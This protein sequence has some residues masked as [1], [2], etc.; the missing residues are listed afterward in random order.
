MP[1]FE[2]DHPIWDHVTTTITELP[3]L[4]SWCDEGAYQFHA[5]IFFRISEPLL[6]PPH[7]ISNAGIIFS[8][9][10]DADQVVPVL[11]N[12]AWM[13]FQG[14]PV[15]WEQSFTAVFESRVAFSA[16]PSTT[17]SGPG[18]QVEYEPGSHLAATPDGRVAV[19]WDDNTGGGT[20]NSYYRL[21]N[22]N[23]TPNTSAIMIRT[24]VRSSRVA[25]MSNM[26]IVTG[27][28]LGAAGNGGFVAIRNVDTG[29]IIDSV[30]FLDS[31]PSADILESVNVAE[32]P[33]GNILAAYNMRGF[34]QGQFRIFDGSNLS[35]EPINVKTF[36]FGS[37]TDTLDL[38]LQAGN[39]GNFIIAYKNESVGS[40][41]Y[42]VFDQGGTLIKHGI[43]STVGFDN[44]GMG[45]TTLPNGNFVVS[46]VQPQASTDGGY[47]WVHL[48][49]GTTGEIIQ[50]REIS[51]PRAIGTPRYD[52]G[53]ITYLRNNN[54][55]G[56]YE[57]DNGGFTATSW[58]TI[59]FELDSDL[60]IVQGISLAF[61][62]RSSHPGGWDLIADT[63][64]NGKPV[65]TTVP[66]YFIAP[67]ADVY[68]QSLDGN[69][70]RWN[71][72]YPLAGIKPGIKALD[73]PDGWAGDVGPNFTKVRVNF[74]KVDPEGA[75]IPGFGN[76]TRVQLQSI[77]NPGCTFNRKQVDGYLSGEEI[78]LPTF[79]EPA[80]CHV[81]QMLNWHQDYDTPVYWDSIEYFTPPNT[82]QNMVNESFWDLAGGLGTWNGSGIDSEDL[83]THYISTTPDSRWH[84]GFRP[85]KIKIT[86]TGG[87]ID[88]LLSDINAEV[89]NN[90]P[91]YVSDTEI[92]LDWVGADIYY[93]TL[94]S[95]VAPFTVTKIEFLTENN[96]RLH[97]D[98][99]ILDETWV[100]G[101]D[102]GVTEYGS[103]SHSNLEW[104]SENVFPAHL[105]NVYAREGYAGV[106]WNEGYRPSKARFYFTGTIHEIWIRDKNFGIMHYSGAT[107]PSSGT[108]VDVA[109]LGFDLQQCHFSSTAGP[110]TVWRIEFLV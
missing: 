104:S 1:H 105:L 53:D 65:F 13:P 79:D 7:F 43:I 92:V 44:G 86:Y 58:D 27:H 78:D 36:L 100:L 9:D 51:G 42:Q 66:F 26:N 39:T 57:V 63:M 70:E 83:G 38:K 17:T 64:Q 47:L 101:P 82:W 49:D 95:N 25:V 11:G 23:M 52:S 40:L 87:P 2:D 68:L 106:D 94:L 32:L 22:A 31:G 74:T 46:H 35:A 19:V 99:K 84:S 48:I 108:I 10:S 34:N 75:L 50:E 18:T 97:W 103:W 85:S 110:F 8:I 5:E 80:A 6:S 91:G 41:E 56:I 54:I 62:F 28:A 59:R 98:W 12:G 71:M 37:E 89:M 96:D 81:N 76:F 29:A 21:Y 16:G 20:W 30:S 4:V 3:D 109:D 69:N 14:N 77:L 61:P 15:F 90:V 55:V 45:M 73:A 33:N 102:P 24:N 88:V 67:S 93:V 60:N 72:T 107:V